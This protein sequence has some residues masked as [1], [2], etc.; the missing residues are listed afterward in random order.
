MLGNLKVLS[1]NVLMAS[2]WGRDY[3]LCFAA[4]EAE[5]LRNS[6][7]VMHPIRGRAST[8]TQLV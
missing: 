5:R 6:P 8:G 7:K 3:H 2:L 4:N 1:Q